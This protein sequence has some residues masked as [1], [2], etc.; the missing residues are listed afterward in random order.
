MVAGVENWAIE[1]AMG[2]ATVS[3]PAYGFPYDLCKDYFRYSDY[4]SRE[5]AKGRRL[6]KD[7]K[8][9]SARWHESSGNAFRRHRI[10]CCLPGRT[11]HWGILQRALHVS[12]S[13]NGPLNSFGLNSGDDWRKLSADGWQKAGEERKRERGRRATGIGQV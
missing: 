13:I 7:R 8:N 6:R 11:A 5:D 2:R 12:N 4:E 3:N 1:G 9:S 10:V